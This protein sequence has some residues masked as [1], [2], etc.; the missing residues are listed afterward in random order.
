MDTTHPSFTED[1]RDLSN[2]I[3]VIGCPLHKSREEIK[4]K[5]KSEDLNSFLEYEARRSCGSYIIIDGLKRSFI[6]SPGF[7][8]GYID[9]G[10]LK[11]TTELGSLLENRTWDDSNILDPVGLSFYIQFNSSSTYDSPVRTPF[12][13]IK[14][15]KPGTINKIGLNASKVSTSTYLQKGRCNNSFSQ[16][17]H[18]AASALSGYNVKMLYSGGK[19]STAIYLALREE[20]G[21]DNV[22]AISV[23]ISPSMVVDVEEINT[24]T[25]RLGIDLTWK[26]NSDYWPPRDKT[27]LKQVDD[28]MRNT[29]SSPLNLIQALD[30][31]RPD[32][33]VISG[34]NMDAM[35]TG[36]MAQGNINPFNDLP[37][38]RSVEDML[39]ITYRPFYY[40]FNRFIPN[41]SLWS[42]YADSKTFRRSYLSIVPI[43]GRSMNYVGVD[44]LD[45]DDLGTFIR[46]SIRKT[47]ENFDPLLKE[48][49]NIDPSVEGLGLGLLT[50]N[51]P[52]I[53]SVPNPPS[54]QDIKM[55]LNE[56]RNIWNGSKH[57]PSEEICLTKY[58]HYGSNSADN[59]ATPSSI[60][61][62]G[63][64][65]C[66]WGPFIPLFLQPFGSADVASPK[67]PVRKYIKQMTGK[68]YEDLRLSPNTSQQ[69]FGNKRKKVGTD[70]SKMEWDWPIIERYHHIL[71]AESSLL[72]RNIDQEETEELIRKKMR[73]ISSALDTPLSRSVSMQLMKAGHRLINVEL[74]LERAEKS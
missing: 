9:K 54:R 7:A 15:I 55:E 72:I 63:H 74:L 21:E 17:L 38:I 70:S 5:Y 25:E 13:H 69:T 19:D 57:L 14:K 50:H 40:M 23:D 39:N 24:I 66:N 20:I 16:A 10:N 51:R 42:G 37:D 36:G 8:G 22:E 73:A 1:L 61:K 48:E 52:S 41:L 56:M 26:R 71:D 2:S 44:D 59:F 67:K 68:S 3:Q 32:E 53:V 34:Q 11:I 64:L 27:Y 35:L 62:G 49:N 31:P 28:L 43:V 6:T 29:L 18:K 46:Y 4:S 65:I 33:Y 47:A 30:H 45:S 12:K 60:R 58:Y